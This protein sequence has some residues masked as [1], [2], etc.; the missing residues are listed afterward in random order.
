[1]KIPG[2]AHEASLQDSS[3]LHILITMLERDIMPFR[4]NNQGWA[5]SHG[6]SG[7]NF[8]S[9]QEGHDALRS[10]RNTPRWRS[11]A[12]HDMLNPSDGDSPTPP[13]HQSPR[14]GS[15][16]DRQMSRSPNTN[17]SSGRSSP[18]QS[19][20]GRRRMPSTSSRPSAARAPRQFRPPYSEE[21]IHFIWYHRIDL[22]YDWSDITRAYNAQFPQRQREGFGGI[23]CKYYRLREAY[24]I[25]RVRL[26]NRSSSPV[27]AYGMQ[28][29][30]GLSYPWMHR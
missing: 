3:P 8:R 19:N 18:T 30:T 14:V 26:R 28:S 5:G 6:S 7:D 12:I 4:Q 16:E 29:T 20:H 15:E 21:E 25:P 1:M 17:G 23:Q 27:D 24:N 10:Q 11:M 13:Q 2:P 9:S 22:G